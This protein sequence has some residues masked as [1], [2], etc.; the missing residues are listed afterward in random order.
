MNK[1]IF[2]IFTIIIFVSCFVLEIDAQ[3]TWNE[4]FMP[5][6]NGTHISDITFTDNLTGY[7]VTGVGQ[8]GY[9]NYILKTT[10]GG[11]NW[12][13]ILSLFREFSRISFINS[14]T[15]FVC[16][17]LNQSTPLIMK[18]TNGGVNWFDLNQPTGNAFIND[19]SFVTE[20]LIWI[21]SW[22]DIIKSTD[23]GNSWQFQYH[24]YLLNRVYMFNQNLGFGGSNLYLFRTTNS[25]NNWSSSNGI[26]FTDIFFV[27]SLSG[28]EAND[29]MYKTINGGNSW[30]YLNL[31]FG[32]GSNLI[33]FSVI[34][35]NI[36]W[37]T[38]GQLYFGNN[39][40]RGIVYATNDGGSTWA[41]QMPDTSFE[42][43]RY[44][45]I[46]FVNTNTGWAYGLTKGIHT[47][48]GGGI[49]T[50]IH[51]KGNEV[52]KNYSLSQNYPNPFNPS[53][54]INYQL[55]KSGEVELIIY[56][57]LGRKMKTLVNEKQ[58]AG[59]YQV[60]F[61]GS[62]FPSGVYFYKL[63]SG[64]YIQTKKMALIK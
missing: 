42:I 18:T 23:G 40:F 8:V 25:G 60:E 51:Q 58:N 33:R 32:S 55:P 38:G 16:G 44:Y 63:Q 29:D 28:W 36:I 15:G 24:S 49:F 30:T 4:Q 26:F 27:D 20:N 64:D 53:T 39:A 12:I 45:F 19:I 35:R 10:N 17:G 22:G 62:N 52:P 13:I 5:N 50:G 9:T 11:D 48:N 56:D 1:F 61:D 2:K 41:Y 54:I 37:G 34:T 57:A 59:S 46:K 43:D 47:T 3:A 14:N 6:L 7:A 31:P 21:A